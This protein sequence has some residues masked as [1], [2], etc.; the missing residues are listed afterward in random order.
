MEGALQDL[1]L[2]S[3]S[4]CRPT[5]SRNLYN[6]HWI[7][8]YDRAGTSNVVREPLDDGLANACGATRFGFSKLFDALRSSPVITHEDA[9]PEGALSSHVIS[10]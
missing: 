3:R 6:P 10:T 1:W 7:T 8:V 5:A 2:R 4:F 9:T